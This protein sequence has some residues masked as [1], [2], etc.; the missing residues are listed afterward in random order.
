[1][2][3]SVQIALKLLKIPEVQELLKIPAVQQL[4]MAQ[5]S[6]QATEL[7]IEEAIQFVDSVIDNIKVNNSPPIELLPESII[8]GESLSP[9]VAPTVTQEQYNYILNFAIQIKSRLKV[10]LDIVTTNVAI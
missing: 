9:T 2:S 7:V 5:S 6:L 1:M 10:L 3:N 4:L 8:E